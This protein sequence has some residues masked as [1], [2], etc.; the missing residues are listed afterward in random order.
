MQTNSVCVEQ[1][2]DEFWESMEEM[3][4]DHVGHDGDVINYVWALELWALKL[5]AEHAALADN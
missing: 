4:L 5:E 1:Q 2:H 3:A